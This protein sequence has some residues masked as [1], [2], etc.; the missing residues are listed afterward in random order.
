MEPRQDADDCSCLGSPAPAAVS[1]RVDKTGQDA[2]STGQTP[3]GTSVLMP[4]TMCIWHASVRVTTWRADSRSYVWTLL[5][6][7]GHAKQG[8]CPSRGL[9]KGQPGKEAGVGAMA[10]SQLRDSM[11]Q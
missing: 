1:Y 3:W 9:R 8:I 6:H 11:W 10:F 2:A 7:F 4:Y 5:C